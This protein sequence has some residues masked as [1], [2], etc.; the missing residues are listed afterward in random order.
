MTAK[1]CVWEGERGIIGCDADIDKITVFLSADA[2]ERAL[3]WRALT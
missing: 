3:R 1:L 2:P